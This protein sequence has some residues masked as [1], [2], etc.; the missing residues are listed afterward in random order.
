LWK[1]KTFAESFP[2][3]G[4]GSLGELIV[5]AIILAVALIPFFAFREL[6]RALGKGVLGALLMKNPRAS[7]EGSRM[8][9]TDS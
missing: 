9:T 7:N 4:G 2:K 3:V 6:S 8:R 1:G 5:V